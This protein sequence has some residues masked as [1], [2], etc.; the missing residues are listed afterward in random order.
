MIISGILLH[1]ICYDFFFVTGYMY[2]ENKA[3]EKIKNAAQ[4]LFTVA[5]YGIGM[6]IGSWFSGIITDNNTIEGIKN[7][8][9][10][11]MIPAYISAAVLLFLI[12]FFKEKK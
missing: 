5:T 6:T 4:G 11:W 1:G 7:W 8:G 2:T 12:V 3:G 9:D 10:I